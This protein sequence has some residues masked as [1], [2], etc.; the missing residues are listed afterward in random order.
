MSKKEFTEVERQLILSKDLADVF[1]EFG[2]EVSQADIL[3]CLAVRG[4]ALVPCFRISDENVASS[5]YIELV[6]KLVNKTS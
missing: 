1:E 3:D 5:A 4:L 6:T 2:H